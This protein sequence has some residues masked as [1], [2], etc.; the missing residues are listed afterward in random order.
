[1]KPVFFTD[2][3]LGAKIFPGILRQEGIGVERHVDHFAPDTPDNQWL[4]L[5]AKKGWYALSND[6]GI[7]RKD[8]ERRVVMKAGVPLFI[9]VGGHVP[10]EQLAYNFVNTLSRIMKFIN[11]NSPPFIAKIYRPNP[12]KAVGD[13]K[14]GRVELKY[15]I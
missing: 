8:V 4:P 14:P 6:R 3:D 7:L 9:L 11:N 15:P 2:R 5:V 12:V 1:M 10:V 13:G